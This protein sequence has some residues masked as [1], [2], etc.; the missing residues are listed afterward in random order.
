MAAPYFKSFR[1][2]DETMQLDGVSERQVEL[3]DLTLLPGLMDMELNFLMGGQGSTMMSSVQAD[4][5]MKV[6][7][8][9]PACRKTLLAG[10]T[11]DIRTTFV[12]SECPFH[13]QDVVSAKSAHSHA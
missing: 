11:T 4:P 9:I 10:F 8:A 6:L 13:S 7:R 2:P 3:G 12:A 5:A 1:D